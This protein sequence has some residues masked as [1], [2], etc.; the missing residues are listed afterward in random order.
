M[1]YPVGVAR[2]VLFAPNLGDV[3]VGR[4]SIGTGIAVAA[5]P[6]LLGFLG[7]HFGVSRGFLMLPAI[8]AVAIVLVLLSPTRK[9]V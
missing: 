9:L 8:I 1:Q 2:A 6:L 7:D 5:G 3:A 4:I